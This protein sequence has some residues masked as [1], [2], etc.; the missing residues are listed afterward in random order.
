MPSI[1]LSWHLFYLYMGSG[2]FGE[3]V[4]KNL[5]SC[6]AAQQ[7]INL[8]L[9]FF[10][11]RTFHPVLPVVR[12]FPGTDNQKLIWIIKTSHGLAGNIAWLI[13][14]LDSH[15]LEKRNHFSLRIHGVRFPVSGVRCQQVNLGIANSEI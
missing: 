2:L 11:I 10:P 3:P 9:D 12:R 7:C 4:M 14:G 15:L 8:V 13:I 6:R 1:I 5:V